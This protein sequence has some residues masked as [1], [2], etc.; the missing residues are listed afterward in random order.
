M[1]IEM[2]DGVIV[3]VR[4][5]RK[6]YKKARWRKMA[7]RLVAEEIP[8]LEQLGIECKNALFIIGLR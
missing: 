8:K 4:Y 7:S 5:Y 1:T 6:G 2:K 3:K